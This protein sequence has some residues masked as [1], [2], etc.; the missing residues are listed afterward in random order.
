MK[1][2]PNSVF[3]KEK[4]AANEHQEPKTQLAQGLLMENDL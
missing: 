4:Y 3:Y 1:C 2:G